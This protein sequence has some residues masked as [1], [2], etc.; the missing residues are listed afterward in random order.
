MRFTPTYSKQI[1]DGD[2]LSG[3]IHQALA[4]SALVRPSPI[5]PAET[6]SSLPIGNECIETRSLIRRGLF[7]S[8]VSLPTNTIASWQQPRWR[9]FNQTKEEASRRIYRIN[10]NVSTKITARIEKS[11]LGNIAV[12]QFRLSNQPLVK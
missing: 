3:S 4:G 11:G 6:Y 12:L 7:S 2:S 10:L 8:C 9:T 1:S 5:S